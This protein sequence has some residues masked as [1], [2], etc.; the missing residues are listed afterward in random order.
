MKT[1]YD[2]FMI[3][4]AHLKDKNIFPFQ[5][6]IFNPIHK[7]YSMF[8]NG[9]RPLTKELDT[10]LTFLVERGAKI[11]VLKKQRR[12]FLTSQDYHESEIPSLKSRELHE[13][14]KERIMNLKFKEMY[15]EKNGVFSFQSEFEIAC[16]TDNF[17]KIIE[18]ARIEILTFSVTQ[19]HTISLALH[20]TKTHLNKDNYL[21]RIVATSYLF[22]K[23][24]N[25]LDPVALSDIICGA[26]LSHIGYTQ[27]PLSM[28]RIPVL[29]LTEKDKK[30][31]EKHT[32]LGNHLIKKSQ[33][34]LT[35]RCKKII[36]DHHER[37]NGGGYP[38]MKYGES[39]EILS[40]IVGSIAH[41]FEFSSGKIN[42]SKL[43][44]KSIII[45]MKNKTFSPGLEFDFG[46]KVYNSLVTLINTDKIEEKKAA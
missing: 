37:I 8:L 46:E 14:E 3:E 36:L 31:F 16:H 18:F 30:L 11:A 17:E 13:L 29:S 19:S 42:G 34:D 21:N 6:Y 1:E 43:P 9:N 33:L 5:I 45:N 20:L 35:E 10:F 38:S 7:K 23:T 12:T 2:F 27:L 40:L 32:I 25:I 4:R 39:I 15:D 44:I 28:L 22:A 41:L 24:A 26:Y